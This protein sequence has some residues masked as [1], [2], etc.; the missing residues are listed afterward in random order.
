MILSQMHNLHVSPHQISS[1]LAIY[2]LSHAHNAA[3]MNNK[4]LEIAVNCKHRMLD[5]R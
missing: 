1:S 4:L 5:N 2:N 3:K